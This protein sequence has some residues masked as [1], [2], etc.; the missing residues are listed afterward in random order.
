MRLW[1]CHWYDDSLS[2]MKLLKSLNTK[3]C[4]C[5]EVG[6][7]WLWKAACRARPDL[8][9][10]RWKQTLVLWV[11]HIYKHVWGPLLWFSWHGASCSTVW[12]SQSANI[13]GDKWLKENQNN[14]TQN[15]QTNPK[16][17]NE[18]SK[19]TKNSKQTNK[20]FP[21]LPSKKEG[22]KKEPW[23]SQQD[24]QGS[25]WRGQVWHGHI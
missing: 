20:T 24:L 1:R 9:L 25:R 18:T 23:C 5:K 7:P 22:R 19:Q 4:V 6:Q 15:K 21:T 3:G 8:F 13:K 10:V 2:S 14:C 17:T 11:F 16:Q 12:V